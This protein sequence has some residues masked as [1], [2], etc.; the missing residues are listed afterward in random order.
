[1]LEFGCGNQMIEE[2]YKEEFAIDS[3]N[4]LFGSNS[5]TSEGIIYDV[6]ESSV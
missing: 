4:P 1:M 2:M 3:N 6:E 5:I